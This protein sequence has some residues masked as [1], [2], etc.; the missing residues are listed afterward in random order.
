MSKLNARSVLSGAS[1]SG[2]NLKVALL[3]IWDALNSKGFTD[4]ARGT[5]TSTS[6]LTVA[7]SGLVLVDA[8]SASIVLTLPVSGASSDDAFFNIRRI[9]ASTSNTVT[10]L[11][12]GTDTLE[13]AA[14]ALPILAGETLDVQLPAG[15]T[16]WR[17]TGGTTWA[18]RAVQEQKFITGTTGG[19][20]TAYT[21]T[22]SPAITAYKA[23]QS[24]FVTFHAA[25]GAS[26][27]LQISGVATPPSL[28]KLLGNGSFTN[29]GAGDLPINHRSRVT[30]IS[31]TQA[32]VEELP[33]AS[34]AP[35]VD[36]ASAATVNLTTSASST[37]HINITGTTTI[38][39]FTVVSGLTYFVRF[40]GSLTLTNSA[41]LVT[42]TG[43][44]I[45]TQ[46]GDTCVLRATAA[47]TV[48]ILFYTPAISLS[49][50]IS[51]ATTSGTAFDFLSIPSGVKRMEL[52]FSG[53]STNGSSYPIV[54]LG[55]GS[56]TVT[57]YSSG[58]NQAGGT[59]VVTGLA[60]TVG[61]LTGAGG[62]AANI[63]YGSMSLENV[64]SN[65]WVC[66]ASGGFSNASYGTS[67]GG[68]VT[69]AGVLDRL[70]LTTINGTD[71]FDNGLVLLRI[72]E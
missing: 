12:N 54:Q 6:T 38:T 30:L 15:T 8:T 14:T 3:A 56:F 36:V 45:V 13:G 27:T 18:G 28:V 5:I 33:D 49:S 62:A 2:A 65:T 22:T 37:R 34:D 42:Q 24:F 9:D 55:S 17:I 1:L 26:P 68:G 25:S 63:F 53:V 70:R 44:N 39:A 43:A 52:I 59:N 50:D 10:V 4:V 66:S 19:T 48:E 40:A 16:N 11:R 58:G 23:G 61:L 46:A 7:Q 60:T 64:G 72:L 35:R 41:S 21:L 31:A 51:V 69:L 20:L 67:C 71:S 32:W 29:I 57:G 47:N